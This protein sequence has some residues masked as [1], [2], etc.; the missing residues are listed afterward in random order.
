MNY[1]LTGAACALFLTSSCVVDDHHNPGPV[2]GPATLTVEWTLDGT[3][4]PSQCRQANA[5][6]ILITVEDD[7]GPV[8]PDI[9]VDCEEFGVDV[10]DLDPGHYYVSALLL[11]PNGDD[12]TTTVESD[13]FSLYADDAFTIDIDFPASSF[14]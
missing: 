6:S 11:D 1:W 4:D 2:D 10:K 3:D 9:Q 7:D 13:R 14:F 5:P 8:G 12:R